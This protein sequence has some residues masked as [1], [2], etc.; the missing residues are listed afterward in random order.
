MSCSGYK[1][2][3]KYVVPKIGSRLVQATWFEARR[4]CAAM[5][6]DLASIRNREEQIKITNAVS[7]YTYSNFWIGGND[8]KKEGR[9]VWSD[10]SPFSFTF[11]SARE[12]NNKGSRGQEDCINLRK[13]TYRRTWNDLACSFRHP[14]ICKIRY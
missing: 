7:R 1:K 6:G 8:L 13:S 3:W 9:F 4:R 11:W 5:H 14:F 10:G 12:P 2:S